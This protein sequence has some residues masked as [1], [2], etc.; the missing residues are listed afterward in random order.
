MSLDPRALALQGVG[1]SPLQMALHGTQPSTPPEES[2]P[3]FNVYGGGGWARQ[4]ALLRK[5]RKRED[6][7]LLLG[8][9]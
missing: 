9:L 2:R 1:F 8:L 4:Q 3:L 7:E 5:R 6:E